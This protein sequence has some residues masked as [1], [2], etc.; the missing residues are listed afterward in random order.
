[1]VVK[2]KKGI[3]KKKKV[4]SDEVERQLVFKEFGQ[5]YA[6]VTKLLG[7]CRVT[8]NCID[9]VSRLC[10]IRGN[11]RKKV[12]IAVDD[13]VLVSLREY[14]DNK[15]DIIYKFNLKEIKKLKNLGEIP[16]SLLTKEPGVAGVEDEEND[17][18]EFGEESDNEEEKKN[19]TFDIV[20]DFETL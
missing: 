15:C 11:M 6:Q 4:S 16:E 17:V 7:S 10:H 12:W 2:K 3:K 13:I 20:N 1:M 8:A 19:N 9:G 14:E 5:E 18:F